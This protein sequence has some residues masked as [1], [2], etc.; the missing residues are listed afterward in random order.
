MG[1][2][3]PEKIS[4]FPNEKSLIFFSL[5]WKIPL[6]FTLVFSIVFSA[7]FY[8]FLGFSIKSAMQMIRVDLRGTITGADERING[9]DLV[10]LAESGVP[11]ELGCSED[12]RWIYYMDWLDTVYAIEPRA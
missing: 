6:G 8:W 9:D 7:V 12:P 1:I 4:P 11:N 5:R 3:Q 2:A 10:A